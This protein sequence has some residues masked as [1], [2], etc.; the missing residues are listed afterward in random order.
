MKLL[1]DQN[2]SHKL[3]SRLADAFP[4]SVQARLIGMDQSDDA[5]LWQYAKAHGLVI[6]TQDVDFVNMSLLHGH[7]PKII[8]LRCGNQP[9]SVIETILRTNLTSI[10]A[11]AADNQAGFM[12]LFR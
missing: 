11:F 2:L 4:G 3:C 5:Q 10:R 12:E 9:S 7:P 6:V 8:W 1:L